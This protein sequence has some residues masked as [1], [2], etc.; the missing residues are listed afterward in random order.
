MDTA[1]AGTYVGIPYVEGG[2][3]REGCNCWGL[4]RLVLAERVGI[5]MPEYGEMS[6]RAIG[7]V[8][9]GILPEEAAS[10]WL[11]VVPVALQELDVV[12]MRGSERL[13]CGVLVAPSSVLHIEAATDSVIVP[14]DHHSIAGRIKGFYR[15]RS[16]WGAA[17]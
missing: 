2:M 3:T 5:V 8:A 4:V 6:A 15:H 11:P 13:H 1:W 7:A 17:A 16:L 14:R 12:L 10:D 9:R